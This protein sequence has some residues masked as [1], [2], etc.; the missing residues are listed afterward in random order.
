MLF[1]RSDPPKVVLPNS[2]WNVGV[3][4]DYI[5]RA[6]Y[7]YELNIKVFLWQTWPQKWLVCFQ[8][9]LKARKH[10]DIIYNSV[11]NYIHVLLIYICTP[12]PFGK[13]CCLL[14]SRL[15]RQP[16][17]NEPSRA[18][19]LKPGGQVPPKKSWLI[20]SI[21]W[22]LLA[23]WKYSTLKILKWLHGFSFRWNHGK[24]C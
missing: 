19:I 16:E 21:N 12:H 22:I 14:I 20:G 10:M 24:P 15:C 3:G 17:R 18:W 5:I 1:N 23:S 11:S 9:R 8:G 6:A 7:L 4:Y 13:I 2:F